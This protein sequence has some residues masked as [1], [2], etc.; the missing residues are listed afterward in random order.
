[1]NNREELSSWMDGEFDAQARP[2]IVT[3]ILASREARQNWDQ[4]HLIGDVM[5]SASVARTTSVAD[6]VAEALADEPVHMPRAQ[7]AR[8]TAAS[9]TRRASRQSVRWF[10]GAAAAAAVA[11]VA[12]LAFT[13]QMQESGV[14]QMLAGLPGTPSSPSST[15]SPDR[16][17]PVVL[18]DSRLRDLIDAHGTMSIRPVAV[19]VR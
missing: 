11:F 10:G 16:L 2:T 13:P 18:E 9:G 5:R 3:E 1:M 8:G 19:E 7:A 14:S 6:R 15:M 17:T 4:W 12:Y